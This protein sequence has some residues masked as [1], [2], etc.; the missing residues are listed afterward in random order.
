[1][2]V[3]STNHETAASGEPETFAVSEMRCEVV[4]VAKGG[5]TLTATLLLI[6][7]DAEAWFAPDVTALAVAR[8]VTAS[9]A[10][11]STGAE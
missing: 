10:G 9:P 6:V 8:S 7:T 4:R 3:A 1:M 2:G 11:R 5:D